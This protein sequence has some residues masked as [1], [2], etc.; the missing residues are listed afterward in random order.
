MPKEEPVQET[1][2]EVLTTEEALAKVAMLL[3]DTKNPKLMSELSMHEIS[4]IAVIDTIATQTNNKTLNDFVNNFLRYR[5]SNSR[6]GRKELMDIATSIRQE[7][8]RMT[9]RIRKLFG[10]GG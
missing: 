3:A 1:G 9:T 2:E 8:E 10:G 4:S 6:K 7:P 5:V